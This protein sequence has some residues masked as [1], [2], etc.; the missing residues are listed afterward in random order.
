MAGRIVVGT[1]S[2]ADPGFVAEWYPKRLPPRERLAWYA[3]RF[4]AVEVNSTFY[5]IPDRGTVAGWDEATPRGFTFDVK[6]HRLLSRHSAPLDS[7]PPDLRDR[8]TTNARGRVV[9]TAELER[10]LVERLLD[11]LGPLCRAAKLDGFLLQLTPAFSPDRHSLDELDGL[12]EALRGHRLAVELRH[13]AWVQGERAARTFAALSERG[14]AFVCTDGPQGKP[15]TLMPP[16]DAVT[17]DAF[18]YL[19]A[20]GRNLEGFT[21]GRSVAERFGWSYSD[22]ELC[23]I[24]GRARHLAEQASDVRVMFNNNRGADAPV[25]AR[26]FRE[27]LG[28]QPPKAGRYPGPPLTEPG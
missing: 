19:R 16:V 17:T 5:A 22:D 1:S 18:A 14:V 9:L 28:G 21:H 11:E 13:R 20:H 7:L 2:W 12:F 25:A 4:E 27:L 15:P 24:A 23:E 26:R 8:A 10:A 3:R 6:L